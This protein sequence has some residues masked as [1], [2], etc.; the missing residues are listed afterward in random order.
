MLPE[1]RGKMRPVADKLDMQYDVV[2]SAVFQ[3]Y[4]VFN[5]YKEA[6]GFYNNIERAK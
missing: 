1:A 2:I 4:N 5:E 6:S 3:S